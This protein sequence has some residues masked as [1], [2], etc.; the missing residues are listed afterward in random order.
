[1][2]ANK[3]AFKAALGELHIMQLGAAVA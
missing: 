3:A 1:M 2:I